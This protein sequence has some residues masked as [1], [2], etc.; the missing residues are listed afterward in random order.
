MSA[1]KVR[2][3]AQAAEH[4][5]GIREY[6]VREFKAP[7]TAKNMIRSLRK[8]MASLSKM[9]T[10]VKTIEEQPWGDKGIRKTRYKNY[11][12]YFWISEET[13]TV[14]VIAVVYVGRDQKRQLEDM[15][16]EE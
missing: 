16:L 12:I 4:L 15:E 1:Y 11:Y 5:R 7:K 8:E 14:Q 10:R 2:I 3:T 13:K 6:I 9:P